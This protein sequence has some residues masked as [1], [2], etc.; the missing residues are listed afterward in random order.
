MEW[1][2]NKSWNG[3]G[4]SCATIARRCRAT[5]AT[6][7]KTSDLAQI[8]RKVVGVG[9]VGTRAFIL[10][11]FGRDQSDPLFLQAKEAQASVLEGS[12][13]TEALTSRTGNASY[14]VST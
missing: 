5:A 3:C 8:G 7:S 13:R 6:C 2:S 9:S 4:P 11:L 1:S 14:T 10:L 12:R